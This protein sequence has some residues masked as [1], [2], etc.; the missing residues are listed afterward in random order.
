MQGP[1]LEENKAVLPFLRW[2]GSKRAVLPIL[3]RFVPKVF[4]KYVEPF[5]G[6]ACL[7]FYLSPS[8]A[9]LADLNAELIDTYRAIKQEPGSVSR[10]LCKLPF[11]REAYYQI[12]NQQFEKG[13]QIRRAARFIYLNRFC[14]NGLYRTNLAGRFNVPFGAPRN[15]TVPSRNHLMQ[16]SAVLA[17]ARLIAGDFERV[18]SENVSKGDFVYLDPPFFQTEG[19]VFRQYNSKP[20]MRHDLERLAALLKQIDDVGA[21]FLLSYAKNNEARVFFRDWHSRTITLQRN[22]AGFAGA[23]GKA[24][25][26]VV[27]NFPLAT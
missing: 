21:R 8:K 18:V 11:G 2:A 23:R 16:C 7:F 14:F 6:S 22:I 19:R 1:S 5:A 15:A 13:D 24:Q 12:R 17:N 4:G 20:F 26:I 27:S 25:E 9:V 10:V 3:S